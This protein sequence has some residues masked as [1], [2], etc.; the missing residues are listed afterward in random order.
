LGRLRR[1]QHV[2]IF[3]RRNIL[4]HTKEEPK[5]E[6]FPDGREVMPDCPNWLL[7]LISILLLTSIILG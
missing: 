7:A 2:N 4:M 5:F 1:K 3:G 6:G